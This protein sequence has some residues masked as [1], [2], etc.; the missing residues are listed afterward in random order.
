MSRMAKRSLL[1]LAALAVLPALPATAS[2][3][4][5]T[6]T[7]SEG[8]V[9]ARLSFSGSAAGGALVTGLSLTVERAG[10]KAYEAPVRSRHCSPC[11]LERFG[12]GPLLVRDLEGNGQPNVIVELYSGGA[13]CCT[14]FQ[15]FS[16][17]PGTMTYRAAEHDFGDPGAKITDVE[18]NGSLQLVTADDRFAYAFAPFAYS[19]LPLQVLA[20]RSGRFADVTRSYPAA[21]A[22]DAAKWLAAFRAERHLQLGNGMIAAWAADE[23]LLGHDRLVRATLSREA[24]RDNLRSRE[25]YGPSNGSFVRALLRFLKRSGYRH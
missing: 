12:G 7:A 2:A 13:H 6:V 19:G 9:G 15:V 20:F 14:I 17:D 23:E 4:Q 24:S 25:S 21:L 18:G 10:A 22:K 16:Y 11:G 3:A 8:A 5:Q 1:L